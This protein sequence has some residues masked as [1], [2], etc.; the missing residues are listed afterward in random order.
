[1]GD[2]II[3][4]N[5]F[6]Q[7]P[8]VIVRVRYC[9][10][11][12]TGFSLV[13]IGDAENQVMA[14]GWLYSEADIKKIW[15]A[16]NEDWTGVTLPNYQAGLD[17]VQSIRDADVVGVLHQSESELWKPLTEKIFTHFDIKPRQLCYAFINIYLPDYPELIN[18]MRMYRVLLVGKLAPMF[19][20]WLSE[21]YQI[22][23]AAEIISNYH[24][25]PRVMASLKHLDYDLA[26][27]SAGSN[28]VILASALGKSGKVALDIGRAMNPQLWEDRLG[29][30]AGNWVSP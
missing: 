26:L 13:R 14:Q 27:I 20:R 30:R 15:W 23:A 21:R 18:L 10:R 1:M 17:L 4:D 25:I 16:R 2:F 28:A 6:V 22:S 8:E 29:C 3:N 19:A 9:L 11:N 5:D 24:Q 7:L 12:Q